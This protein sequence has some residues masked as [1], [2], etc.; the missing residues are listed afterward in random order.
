MLPSNAGQVAARYPARSGKPSNREGL[1]HG[2]G[3]LEPQS[4]IHSVPAQAHSGGASLANPATLA[5]SYELAKRAF[6][7]S[8][9]ILILPGVAALTALIAAAIAL[10]TGTPTFFRHRRI[11]RHG[12]E[13]DIWKFRTMHVESE[14]LL[15]EHLDRNPSAQEEWCLTHKLKHDPRVTRLGRFLRK[16]SLDELPQLFNIFAG[17]MSFVGPRPITHAET[18][19]YADRLPCYL[20]ALPGITGLWQVSGRCNLSY[21]ARVLLDETYVRQWTLAR[22]LLILLK[23]P[24]AVF[25]R[26]GAY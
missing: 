16:T 4:G 10:T 6:D 8:L 2:V 1:D 12:R 26:H 3:L 21:E 19:R 22:D 23:T 11:G 9:A 17:N 5:R 15:A 7:L 25:C 14:R 13:F 24:R 18:A 20:A